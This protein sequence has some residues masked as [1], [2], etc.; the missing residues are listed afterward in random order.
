MTSVGNKNFKNPSPPKKKQCQVFGLQ[1][2]NVAF[3]SFLPSFLPP[4]SCFF[5]HSTHIHSLTDIT[6][7]WFTLLPPSKRLPQ[8][9]WSRHAKMATEPP[10]PC[11]GTRQANYTRTRTSIHP[12]TQLA[13]THIMSHCSIFSDPYSLPSFYYSVSVIPRN[14]QTEIVQEIYVCVCV[15]VKKC[16]MC[17][18]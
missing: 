10:E 3:F 4:T 7:V 8:P 5:F 11:L 17:V 16:K 9:Q 12:Q 15:C 14:L 13:V 2:T 6:V 18:Q 1:N